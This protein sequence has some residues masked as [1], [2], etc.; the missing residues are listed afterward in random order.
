VIA[1]DADDQ[2]Q[3]AF[4][5]A[6]DAGIPVEALQSL[7]DEGRAKGYSDGPDRRRGPG[8]LGRASPSCGPG[9]DALE[10]GVSE[11]VLAEIANT[12]CSTFN[13][14]KDPIEVLVERLEDGFGTF[15]MP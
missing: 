10:S 4:D 14:H 5:Q 2:I 12:A 8:L 15:G 13:K 9:A 7:V 6:Q 3:S 1:Q 11:A